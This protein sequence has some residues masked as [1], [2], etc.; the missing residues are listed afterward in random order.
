MKPPQ[1]SAVG[2][3]PATPA[4]H[5]RCRSCGQLIFVARRRETVASCPGPGVG[6]P[7]NQDFALRL[8]NLAD[9]NGL[10]ENQREVEQ[11]VADNLLVLEELDRFIDPEGRDGE[12]VLHNPFF[13]LVAFDGREQ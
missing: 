2:G 6:E 12:A 13:C 11:L 9:L 7:V 4:A 8:I 5:Q 3:L 10:V 1:Q